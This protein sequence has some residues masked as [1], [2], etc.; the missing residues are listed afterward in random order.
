M[1]ARPVHMRPDAP[2][3][4]LIQEIRDEA[5]RF[6]ITGHRA[7][8][9]KARNTSRLEDIAGS[10]PRGTKLLAAFGGIDGVRMPRWKTSAGWMGSTGTWRTDI[11]CPAIVAVN[12]HAF[13]HTPPDLGAHRAD[14]RFRRH[15][16]PAGRRVSA[17]GKNLVATA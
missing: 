9:A 17:E 11:Q 6:A 7:R 2:A 12:V 4:H 16:L 10:A 15:L 14:P 1:V 5:H 8:R 13:Q 3:L